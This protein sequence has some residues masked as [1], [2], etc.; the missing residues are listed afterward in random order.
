MWDE[1]FKKDKKIRKEIIRAAKDANILDFIENQK[2]G[3]NSLVGERGILLSGGQKQRLFIARELYRN[4]NLLLLDEATSSLDSESEKKVQKS[5]DS[6]KGKMTVIIVA[7]RL[8]TLKNV[9]KIYVI[10]DG[11]MLIVEVFLNY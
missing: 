7:H 11:K 6:L 4:P 3:F 9:D 2:D 5:I 8:S 10:N 1:D